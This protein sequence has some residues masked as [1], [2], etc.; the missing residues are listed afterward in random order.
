MSRSYQTHC[1][2]DPGVSDSHEKL[3]RLQIPEELEGRSFLDIGCNEGFF[4][5]VAAQ[6]GASRVVGIDFSPPSIALARERYGNSVI[7]YR[8]QRWDVLPNEI[9][10]VVL[11]SSAMHYELDPARIIGNVARA[12]RQGGLFILECGVAPGS[13]PEMVMVQRHNDT[14]WY[15]TAA[16]LTGHLLNEFSFRQVSGW[17]VVPGDPIPRF[18]YHCRSRTPTVLLCRGAS[19][20]GKTSLARSFGTD[21]TK[22]ISLDHFLY[23]ISVAQY[24]HDAVQAYIKQHFQNHDLLGIYKGI[25]EVGLTHEYIGHLISGIAPSDVTV[26]IEGYMTDKQANVLVQELQGRAFVWDARRLG[27]STSNAVPSGRS[28]Q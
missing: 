10:D 25:D 9:F 12:L 28:G 2:A 23:R 27:I 8:V 11:W 3:I 15:P 4:C 7:E 18:V 20:H 21:S 6:R 19:G 26:I 13:N 14:R 17:K 5:N 24:Q 1:D 22:V 16:F